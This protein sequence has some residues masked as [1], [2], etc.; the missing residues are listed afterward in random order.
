[1]P[2]EC[3]CTSVCARVCVHA[4]KG[5][6][7]RT[8]PAL[9]NNC[10]E[11]FQIEKFRKELERANQKYTER[12]E[13]WRRCVEKRHLF[14]ERRK[15]LLEWLAG[16]EARVSS[17]TKTEAS[18]TGKAIADFTILAKEIVSRTS[19]TEGSLIQVHTDDVI[20]KWKQFLRVF[21]ES[22]NPVLSKD[23]ERLV[24]WVDTS[25]VILFL[26]SYSR[27]LKVYKRVELRMSD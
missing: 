22:K 25:L 7:A 15:A 12:R 18:D 23:L 17:V 21:V 2:C 1:M 8:E 6:P 3:V 27:F 9:F 24:H 20:K 4:C 10:V 14:D 26:I 19:P 5:V 16:A 13:L 11:L